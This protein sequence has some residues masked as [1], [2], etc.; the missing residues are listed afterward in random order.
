MQYWVDFYYRFTVL[1]IIT[2]E[3]TYYF[4]YYGYKNILTC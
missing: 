4:K 3:I 2:G 1:F